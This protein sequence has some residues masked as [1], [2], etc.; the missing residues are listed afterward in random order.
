MAIWP[1]A[2]LFLP[3]LNSIAKSRCYD[4]FPETE[5]E[6]QDTELVLWI[7]IGVV[8]LASRVA[9]LAYSPKTHHRI[10]FEGVGVPIYRVESLPEVFNALRK[11]VIGELL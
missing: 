9:C 8:L 3:A 1:L 10:V 2:F 11:L 4:P 6:A 7:G 5:C